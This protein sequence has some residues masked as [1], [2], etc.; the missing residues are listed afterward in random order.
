MFRKIT[1][2]V[3]GLLLSFNCFSKEENNR[4]QLGLS[5]S[6]KEKNNCL[7]EVCVE[8]EKKPNMFDRLDKTEQ[9]LKKDPYSSLDLDSSGEQ[10]HFGLTIPW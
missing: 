1:L 6:Q 10:S 3:L 9:R 7:G 4:K 2:I 5:W 8:T